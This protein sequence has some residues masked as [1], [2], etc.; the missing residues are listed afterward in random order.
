[1]SEYDANRM[2]DLIEGG[3][4]EREECYARIDNLEKELK[5]LGT[6][7]AKLE[8]HKTNLVESLRRNGDELFEAKKELKQL[9]EGIRNL[10]TYDMENISRGYHLDYSMVDQEEPLKEKFCGDYVEV[11]ALKKLLEGDKGE[12]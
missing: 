11:E 12:I 1:M 7:K 6:E 3:I 10:K 9:K 2:D 5:E 4:H 8:Q